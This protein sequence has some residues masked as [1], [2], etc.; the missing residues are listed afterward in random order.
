M[1]DIIPT[2]GDVNQDGTISA[3][4]AVITLQHTVGLIQLTSKQQIAANVSGGYTNVS[5]GYSGVTAFDVLLILQYVFGLI[6][7]FPVQVE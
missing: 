1:V 6:T 2:Y 4:D 5:G 3:Y 7:Q